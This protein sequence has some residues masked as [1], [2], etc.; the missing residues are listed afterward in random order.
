MNN[1][2]PAACDA[3][4]AKPCR[5]GDLSTAPKNCPS[6]G[7]SPEESLAATAKRTGAPPVLRPKSNAT[8]IAA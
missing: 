8:D 2:L 7:V 5:S 3:C 4:A 6:L 1:H